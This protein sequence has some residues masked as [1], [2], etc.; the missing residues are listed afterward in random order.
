M[1]E[2]GSDKAPPAVISVSTGVIFSI[3]IFTLLTAIGSRCKHGGDCLIAGQGNGHGI[4]IGGHISGPLY[5]RKPLMGNSF[6]F[7]DRIIRKAVVC[8][9]GVGGI[10]VHPNHTACFRADGHG[11]QGVPSPAGG[12]PRP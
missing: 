5:K 10:P 11:Q 1:S 6:K 4:R 8:R 7:D 9:K 12:L 3:F 2:S